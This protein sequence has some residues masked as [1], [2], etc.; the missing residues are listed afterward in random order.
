MSLQYVGELHM[1]AIM[2]TGNMG[3]TV[4]VICTYWLGIKYILILY[5]ACKVYDYCMK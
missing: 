2:K 5:I 4:N 1:H 3:N